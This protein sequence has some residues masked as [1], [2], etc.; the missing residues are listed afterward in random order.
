MMQLQPPIHE[1]VLGLLSERSMRQG[2][3]T[4]IVVAL[5]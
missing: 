1:R 3:G 4:P 5:I 2:R